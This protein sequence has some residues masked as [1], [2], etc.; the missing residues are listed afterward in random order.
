MRYL[1]LFLLMGTLSLSGCARGADVT[2]VNPYQEEIDIVLQDPEVSSWSK[3]VLDD[4]RVTER[5]YLESFER[6]ENCVGEVGVTIVEANTPATRSH[7][8]IY[9]ELTGAD[10]SLEETIT[11]HVDTC[12]NEYLRYTQSWFTTLTYNPQK[13]DMKQGYLDCLARHGVDEQTLLDES[14]DDGKNSFSPLPGAT[15][16][17]VQNPATQVIP[18]EYEAIYDMCTRN[19]FEVEVPWE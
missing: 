9:P 18:P 3:R 12:D 2:Q 13:L 19:P 15:S 1:F 7:T 11:A 16:A 4:Y 14:S 17:R 5:E 6:Y 10:P 8:M